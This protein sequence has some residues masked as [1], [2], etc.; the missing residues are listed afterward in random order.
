[1]KINVGTADR[2]LR[3]GVGVLLLGLAA[4][5][6][7]GAWGYVGVLPLATGLFR[8]CPAYSLFGISSCRSNEH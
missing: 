1:M 4:A 8:F 2:V 7:V 6:V 3:I 5:G